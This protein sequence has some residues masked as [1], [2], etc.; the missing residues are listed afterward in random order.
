[1]LHLLLTLHNFQELVTILSLDFL[2]PQVIV[3]ELSLAGDVQ[4]LELGFVSLP[5][6][7]LSL[8]V[9]NL[10]LL[11]GFLGPDLVKSGSTILSL[12]LHLSHALD[13][14]LLFLFEALIF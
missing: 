1:M 11:V 4:L 9:L 2:E 12:L 7:L 14:L 13:F 5:L 8:L 6:H 3:C 10:C